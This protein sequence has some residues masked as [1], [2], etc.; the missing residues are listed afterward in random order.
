MAVQLV[1]D[2]G[3]GPFDAGVLANSWRQQPMGP[4]YCTELTLDQMGPAPAAA[5]RDKDVR[6]RDSMLERFATL[7]G[8][9]TLEDVVEVNRAAHRRHRSHRILGGAHAPRGCCRCSR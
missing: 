7:G 3:F 1:D 4:A 8:A 6:V 2:T 5:D 9:P